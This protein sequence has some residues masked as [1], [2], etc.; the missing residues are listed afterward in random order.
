MATFIF[1]HVHP[2]SIEITF[3]FPEFAP[4]CK[5]T[6]NKKKKK[7]NKQTKKKKSSYSISSFLGYSQF[8]GPVTRLATPF[9]D[10]A[11]PKIFDQFLF[12]MNMYQYAQNQDILVID[13]K[14]PQ[15]D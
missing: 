14:I 7:T 10:Q 1:D 3:S 15:S 2:K 12:Y 5:K 13:K 9:F 6:K 11:H 4:A 8:Q